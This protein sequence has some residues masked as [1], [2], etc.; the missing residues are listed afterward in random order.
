MAEHGDGPVLV[1]EQAFGTRDVDEALAYI[2][3]MY[4][5]ARL[6]PDGRPG[7]FRYVVSGRSTPRLKAHRV[8][9][10]RGMYLDTD[11]FG[12]LMSLAPDRGQRGRAGRDYPGGHLPV[13]GGDAVTGAVG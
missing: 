10:L 11:P 9:C 3:D 13:P 4:V 7:P 6:R 1:A 8:G 12:Y 2:G 5:G